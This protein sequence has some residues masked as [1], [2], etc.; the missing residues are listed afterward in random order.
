MIKSAGLF[1]L[2]SSCLWATTFTY[3]VTVNTASLS[4]TAGTIDFQFNPGDVTSDI[5]NAKISNFTITGPG[6]LMGAPQYFGDASGTLPS[7]LVV[8]NTFNDNEALQALKFGSALA[9]RVTLNEM[10][11]GTAHAGSVFNFSVFQTDGFTPLLTTD[12]N[13]VLVSINLDTKGASSASTTS[14]FAT[15][16]SAVPEPGTIVLIGLG[17]LGFTAARKKLRLD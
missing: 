13:G 1:F 6:S 3:N 8:N 11:T 7:S 15:V 4:T 9:F 10:L 5:A 2:A 12:P 14:S 17:V 16:L